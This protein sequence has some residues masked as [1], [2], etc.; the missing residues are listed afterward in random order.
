MK[1]IIG[2]GNPGREYELTRHNAGFLVLDNLLERHGGTWTSTR[3]NGV[4]AR[5]ALRHTPVILAKPLTYMNRSGHFVSSILN[6]FRVEPAETLVVHDEMDLPLGRIRMA[7]GGGAAGHRGV[8]SIIEQL[9]SRAFPRLRVGV[10]KPV[11]TEQVVGHV[12]SRF[13]EEEWKTFSEV[14]DHCVEA[15]ATWVEHGITEA[16]NQYNGL[17]VQQ[18]N[19]GG[20]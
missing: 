8:E 19:E 20:V 10:G 18:P 3:W 17:N 9:G 1:A 4:S 13:G 12:L 16:M 5:T 14:V 6:Y 7:R 15:A 11:A 2:L